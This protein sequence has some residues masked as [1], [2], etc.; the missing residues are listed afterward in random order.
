MFNQS[1]WRRTF[2]TAAAATL[3]GSLALAGQTTVEDS[4]PLQTTNWNDTLTIP[5]FDP[6]LGTLNSV[7]IRFETNIEGSIGVEN[8]SPNPQLLSATLRATI[9]LFA[10]DMVTELLASS[11]SNQIPD[12]AL[13]TFDGMIDFG[14]PSG[15]TSPQLTDNEVGTL[16]V[17]P[18]GTLTLAQF[19]GIGTVSFPAAAQGSSFFTGNTGNEASVFE[20]RAAAR[21]I[22]T[23][24]FT[25]REQ[26]CVPNTKEVPGSLLLFPRFDNRTNTITVITVTNTNCDFTPGPGPLLNGT[27]D[28]EYVYIG[29]YGPNGQELDCLE[30]NRTRRLTPCD[31]ITLLTRFDNPQVERGFLY[32]FAKDP[33]SGQAIVWNHLIGQALYIGSN[34][35]DDDPAE[36]ALNARTFLGIGADRTPTDHDGDGIRDLDDVEYSEAPD[37]ILI[38]RFLGQDGDFKGGP[39]SF[40]SRLVLVG[41]SGGSQF[42]TQVL[43][44]FYNDN[45]VGFSTQYTF[46]CWDDP[47][48]TDIDDGFLETFLDGT[49]N[50]VNEI[51]GAPDKESGWMRID[52]Q[53]ALSSADVI[54]DPAIYAVLFERFG[55]FVVC[56]L[57]W[58]LCTQ[59]NGDLFPNGVIA[60]D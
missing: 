19:T 56:D 26:P 35:I 9:R 52:G 55:T 60:E 22:V 1:P 30:T 28:V 4:I 29:R 16:T 36:D 31:T 15:F 18:R 37:E 3:I 6:V 40:H 32:V 46:R 21:L 59:N 24:D 50:A 27:V 20:L 33:Q 42:T 48:L 25:G 34:A 53:I 51:I 8:T 43:I 2:C 11:P 23:Y 57:P 17:P 10:P 12:I 44:L 47:R 38:P 54:T 13:A 39:S 41:L 7:S 45:E 5:Q 14:G 58:E 49:D